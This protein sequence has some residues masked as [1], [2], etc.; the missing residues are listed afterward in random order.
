GQY[1]AFFALLTS[2]F[3]VALGLV[4]FW[5]DGLKLKNTPY[6]RFWLCL[7]IFIPPLIFALYYPNV[8]LM[9]LDYAGVFGCALLLGL[10]PVLMVWSGRYKLGMEGEYR[11]WGGKALLCLL[12]AFVVLELVCQF[13]L[14]TK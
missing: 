2:F 5:A 12:A 7:L 1:F 6:N 4:D 9:A 8:F 13:H 14:I 10:L 3:G 11:L